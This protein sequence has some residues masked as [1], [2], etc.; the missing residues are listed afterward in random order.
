M[1]IQIGSPSGVGFGAPSRS[2]SRAKRRI[3]P[4]FSHLALAELGP[5]FGLPEYELSLRGARIR[6]CTPE[7]FTWPAVFG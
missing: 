4:S 6:W 1:F 5:M 3:L 2:S 7:S